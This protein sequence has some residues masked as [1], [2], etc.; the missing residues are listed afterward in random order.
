MNLL[1][2]PGLDS[3]RPEDAQQYLKHTGWKRAPGPPYPGSILYACKAPKE[4]EVTVQLLIDR[5]LADYKRR[6][7]E[8]VE[9]LSAF[10]RRSPLEVLGDLLLPPSDALQ[11]RVHSDVV[12][13][14]FIPLDD[15][16]RMRKAQRQL[17]LACAHSELEPRNHFPRLSQS[18]AVD[19]VRSCREGPSARGSYVT[20]LVV[21]MDPAVGQLSIEPFARR[22]TRRLMGALGETARLCETQDTEGL[23]SRASM[24]IS[25]NFLLALSELRPPGERSYV[26]MGIAW[27][28]ARPAPVLERSRVRFSEGV[29]GLLAEAGQ[30]LRDRTPTAGVEAEG[31]VV[32]LARESEVD[33]AGE[34]VIAGELGDRPGTSMVHV[35]LDRRD[36]AI[37]IEAHKQGQQ[38][39]V[40]GT[41]EVE[42]RTLRLAKHSGLEL[43]GVA[44]G[45]SAVEKEEEL[46]VIEVM[47]R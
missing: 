22:V 36:Y 41:L 2:L 17:L 23:L 19:L 20:T 45:A 34:I 1:D 16:I 30:A 43:L 4:G 44:S 37:A 14:G 27:S 12:Q 13:S 42:R 46:V 28:R 26:E 7:A 38:V 15:S 39:R 3:I 8:L 31:F 11:C 10:E 21:P 18:E 9:V 40:R 32:R 25:A 24:G 29:F 6:M 35:V 5:T 33:K 47:K